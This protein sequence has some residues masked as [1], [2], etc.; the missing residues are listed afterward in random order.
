MKIGFV[1]NGCDKHITGGVKV[2]FQYANYLAETAENNVTLYFNMNLGSIKKIRHLKILQQYVADKVVQSRPKWYKLNPKIKKKAVLLIDDTTIDNEDV[3][4]ATAVYTANS[5]AMLSKT[6]G[7]KFYFI[8]GFE[9][10]SCTDEYVFETY[11][12]GMNNITVAKWLSEIVDTKAMKKS[13]YVSNGIDTD[14]FY[15]KRAISQ[16]ARH[17]IAMQYRSVECKGSKYALETIRILAEKYTDLKVTVFSMEH[18]PENLPSC[19]N[20]IMDASQEKVAEINNN[21]EIFICSSI[22]EGFGLPGLEAMACGCTLVATEC[23]GTLDYAK[24]GEN[25][26]ISPVK[27]AWSMAQN[28]IELFENSDLRIRLAENAQRTAAQ[29]SVKASAEKF[30]QALLQPLL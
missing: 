4:I 15:V 14:I 26:L 27:D 18:E 20:F 3:I 5:V 17:S 8:Q 2:I 25:A 23:K 10:W 6:R 9:N 13:V 30:A 12:L 16:R 24:H 7:R 1:L 19:C 28:I 11:K 22:V 21:A 29:R